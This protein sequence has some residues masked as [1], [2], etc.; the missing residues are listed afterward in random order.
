MGMTFCYGYIWEWHSVMVKNGNDILLC[1]YSIWEWHSVMGIYGNDILLWVYMGVTFG[2]GYIWEWHSV[3]GIY[4][5]DIL[6][7]VYMGMTFCY[8]YT[9]YGNDI[10]LWVYM[11]VTFCYG[12]IW[13]WHSVMGIYGSDIR[14]RIDRRTKTQ[15]VWQNS[16]E[17]SYTFG[18]ESNREGTAGDCRVGSCISCISHQMLIGCLNYRG[19]DDGTLM[20]GWW[21]GG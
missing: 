11:G 15:A 4:G 19:W 20:C 6:L 2:Y 13:E 16:A 7:W 18:S 12:Y 1:V 10:L 14:S 21:N 5:S 8:A 9:V 3:M 17:V